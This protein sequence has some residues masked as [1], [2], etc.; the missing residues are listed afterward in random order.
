M[1]NEMSKADKI[2]FG[3]T[4]VTMDPMRPTVEAIAITGDKISAVG[5]LADVEA[6]SGA[7][8]LRENLRGNTLMP[9]LFE[10]HTHA[11][12]GACRD[13][14]EVYVGY[15]ASLRDIE[16]A[17]KKRAQ[18]LS[19]DTWVSGGPWRHDML[20]HI[21]MTPR[22]WLDRIAP[23]HPVA[24]FDTTQHSLWCNSKALMMSGLEDGA[25]DVPGG[26]IEKDGA[27]RLTGFLA[28]AACAPVRHN[29]SW[30]AAQLDQ[31]CSYAAQY[32]N[33]L[34]YTAF[35]EPMADREVLET[36]ARACDNG[37]MTLHLGAHIS[38]FSPIT[39][40]TLS[41]ETICG[42]R[43]EFTRPGMNLNFSKLFLDGVAPAYTASF[44]QPYVARPGYAPED[45][46]PNATLLLPP[47]E[48]AEIVT[49]HDAYGFCVK[50]HAVGD[51]AA[52]KGLDAIAAA[53]AKNGQSG[54]RHEIAHC[55]FI[56]DEDLSRFAAL[57][58]V[59]EVS[60]KLWMPNA[61]TLAQAVALGKER[62][63]Q[64]HRIKSLLESGADVIFGTDWPASA[65]DANP[66]SGLSGMIT[67]RD[68]SGVFGGSVAPD[69]AVSL[70]EA[71]PLFTTN[72]ARALGLA[73]QSGQV[74]ENSFADYIIL[75]GDLL[76]QSP[77]EIFATEV[78]RTV[79]K[80]NAVYE[81]A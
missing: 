46:N 64:V 62:L 70:E 2:F 8:T 78:Q 12:W 77:E 39:D 58:A 80:G 22:D 52:R 24:L 17:V 48:L 11:L 53:R 31:A 68:V 40:E 37:T 43:R 27:G 51:N 4:I 66:W 38:A 79:F 26:V 41:I 30:T 71:L 55:T 19:K 23:E 65:P 56:S 81:A 61:A 20:R 49:E 16:A 74:K 72:P 36:Y 5:T 15:T 73:G 9:G 75:K 45:H 18:E 50:M 29:L 6:L 47:E 63:S 35:K 7:N 3:G 34:G 44:L 67:R 57:N 1:G 25:A 33:S 21:D 28:E 76:S 42:L 54:L 13:L 10:S 14:F 32:F 60:P 69:E 59:A